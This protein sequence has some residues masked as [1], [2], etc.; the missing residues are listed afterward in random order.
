M[1]GP[2][3]ICVARM[4]TLHL[5]EDVNHLLQARHGGV[6]HVVGQD[7]SEGLV[8]HQFA[9]H[10]AR[11][12]PGQAPPSDA[13]ETCTMLDTLR[14]SSSSSFLPRDSRLLSSS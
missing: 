8:A 3:T 7:D 4:P 10:A 9:R 6:D 1:A 12:V 13:Q 14:L 5:V 2:S 11:R